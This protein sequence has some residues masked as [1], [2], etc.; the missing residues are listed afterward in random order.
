VRLGRA[1]MP[2]EPAAALESAGYT[3]RAWEIKEREA[4]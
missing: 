3:R 2:F 4:L 1:G